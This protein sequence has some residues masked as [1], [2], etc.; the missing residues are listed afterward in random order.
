MTDDVEKVPEQVSEPKSK[1]IKYGYIVAIII[2]AWMVGMS[3]VIAGWLISKQIQIQNQQSTAVQS[4]ASSET[5]QS[6]RNIDIKIQDDI[7]VLGNRDAKVTVVEFGDFQCPFCGEF[8]SDVFKE[9][10][11][12][13]FSGDQ[14]KFAFFDLPFLGEESVKASEASRCAGDQGKYW[15]YHNYL[16]EHQ[17][18][19]NEGAFADLNL[20]S[21]AQKLGLDTQAFNSC[22]DDRKYKSTVAN[23]L[24][25]ADGYGIDSTPTIFINGKEMTAGLPLQMYKLYI[26]SAISQSYANK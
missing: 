23:S 15:E 8:H 16:Y 18:G 4:A 7:P 9:L 24:V 5:S 11:K 20:K 6:P 25:T 22:F 12:T 26:D 19:E 14:V 17:S 1:T 3:I 21:F 10:S 13:Y 2:S